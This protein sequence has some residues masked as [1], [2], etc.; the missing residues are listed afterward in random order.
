MKSY[1]RNSQSGITLSEVVICIFLL[2]AAAG[3]FGGILTLAGAGERKS[4]A[5]QYLKEFSQSAQLRPVSCMSNDND[6]NQYISCT[7]FG[8]N[9][10]RVDIECGYS[11][12]GIASN[13]GCRFAPER[14]QFR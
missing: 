9:N 2:T 6:G 11:V 10:E 13:Q 1:Q 12:L 7:A 14:V 5:E 8:T 4:S 3:L